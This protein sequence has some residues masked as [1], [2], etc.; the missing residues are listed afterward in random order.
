MGGIVKGLPRFNIYRQSHLNFTSVN[1]LFPIVIDTF[2]N[3]PCTIVLAYSFNKI[4]PKVFFGILRI[5]SSR[6]FA[7]LATLQTLHNTQAFSSIL[8]LFGL[9]TICASLWSTYRVLVLLQI[10]Q[11]EPYLLKV[12]FFSSLVKSP[13]FALR[14]FLD[15]YYIPYTH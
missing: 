2:S 11:R 4:G 3:L 15:C 7:P 10:W 14:F 12:S 8:A 6:I 13:P 5:T 9:H 1:C